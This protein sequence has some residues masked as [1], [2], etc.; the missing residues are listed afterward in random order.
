VGSHGLHRLG[1]HPVVGASGPGAGD[2]IQAFDLGLTVPA[3]SLAGDY[4][5]T[6]TVTIAPPV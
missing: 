4:A 1:H 6:L 2:Y 3:N 5:G